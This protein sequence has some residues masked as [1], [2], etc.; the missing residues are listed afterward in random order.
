[1]R[2]LLCGILAACTFPIAAQNPASPAQNG[3][4]SAGP[5][6]ATFDREH[7]PITAGGLVKTGPVVLMEI[8]KQAGLTTWRNVTGTPQKNIIV[9]AK[10]SGVALLDYDNDGWLDI[11]MVNGSTFDAQTG[12]TAPPHAALFHNN[13]DGT[14]TDVAQQAGV[15]ND[16][17][18]L[19]V[20]VGDYDNDGWPDLYVTNLGTNRLYHNNRNGTFTDVAEK[21]G[22]ALDSGN[23]QVVV[24]HTGAT[25]GDYDGD[26]RLDLFVAGYI[27]F[28]FQNP[29]IAGT[30]ATSFETCQYRS[31]NVM[32]GPRGL[33]GAGDH[34]FHNNGDGTFTDVSEKAGVSDRSGFYGLGALFVDVNN[35]GRPDLLVADDSTPNYL[36]INKG[37]GTF[38]DDSYSS[39]Y[40]LN[41]DGREVSNMGI[42][43]GDYEN[44][45]HLD[46]VNTDFSDDYDVVF[47]NDGQ[48]DFSDVS[49]RSGIASPTIPFVG[50]G[51]GFLDY[52]NDGWKDLFI[53][54][55]HVYP[56]ADQHPEWG[57]SYAQRPLLFHNLQNGKFELVPA[58]EGAGLATVAVGRGAA[59]GD[60]FNDGKIDVVINN[61]DGPPILLRNVNPDRHH[62]IE[63]KLT[64]N[65]K[66]P[67]DAVGTTVYLTAGGIRQREDV[68]SGGSYLSSSDMRAHF[69]L[70]EA[71]SVDEVEIHWA[72]GG[73]EKLKPPAV[74]RIYSVEKGK[75]I[76][77]FLC[78]LC[79]KGK[80]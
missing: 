70:G 18:G 78:T 53:V 60:L 76:T 73:I 22:V 51:D 71:A 25:F 1:M 77:G 61:L 59:F 62:W 17:W 16:R 56:Q 40:A 68:M 2:G 80:Q 28:D 4:A 58:V 65:G 27:H 46:L 37:D 57:M 33:E 41:G 52:D 14:F 3:M 20:A 6:A 79:K 10:G 29:P 23:P 43:A 19:G 7:R 55:G 50:F 35:D 63:F 24:D 39:G 72:G 34:L 66:T 44:N 21:A 38:E 74:D 9:E 11:Y 48:G 75:G 26:G 12:K 42:A 31:L 32:C 47:L 67:R 8:A 64:G 69:G 45:G 30:K 36:Y 15:T 5:Q 49:Y 13:R 54:N